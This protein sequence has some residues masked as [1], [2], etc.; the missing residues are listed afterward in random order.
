MASGLRF[1]KHY[2]PNLQDC[3]STV[4]FC[5]WINALFDALNRTK[6][7]E[8]MTIGELMT[9]GEWIL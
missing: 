6:S 5:E 2:V 8:G 9:I 3:D 4:N 1:Y 7:N